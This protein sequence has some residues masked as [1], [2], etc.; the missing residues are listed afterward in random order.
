MGPLA[1]AYTPQGHLPW[2]CGRG[3]GPIDRR[4]RPASGER[5]A[6]VARRPPLTTTAWPSGS[7]ELKRRLV[8]RPAGRRRSPSLRILEAVAT[9][10][11]D[12]EGRWSRW[13]PGSFGDRPPPTCGGSSS[14][15][16][17]RPPADLPRT[18]R[19][20]DL[21]RSSCRRV[22]IGRHSLW[23]RRR[24]CPQAR[25]G[26]PDWPPLGRHVVANESP[27]PFQVHLVRMVGQPRSGPC[28]MPPWHGRLTVRDPHTPAEFPWS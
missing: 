2:R 22:T 3:P 19:R 11:A 27:G 24:P 5:A 15:W 25:R 1:L 16:K 12:R 18:V 17:N 10:G 21:Q 14:Y 13:W 26:P 8:G 4:R 20:P 23:R 7:R 9:R 28:T 6:A